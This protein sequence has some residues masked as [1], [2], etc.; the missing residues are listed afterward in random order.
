MANEFGQ[1]FLSPQFDSDLEVF[2]V[3]WID[4]YLSEVEFRSGYDR[5]SIDR[6][7]SYNTVFDLDKY[8]EDALPTIAIVSAGINDPPERVG[9]GKYNGWWDWACVVIVGQKDEQATRIVAQLYGAAIRA[10]VLQ[11][12]DIEGAVSDTLYE[13]ETYQYGQ[14]TGRSR[15]IGIVA[16]EFRSYIEGLIQEPEGPALPDPP[17][18]VVTPDDQPRPDWPTVTSTHV[19]IEKDPLNA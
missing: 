18:P 9:N 16:L 5:R 10:M 2:F 4:T 6:P 8:P 15:S 3:K 12:S 11:H 1:I 14:I 17:I 13:S 19:K 7:R